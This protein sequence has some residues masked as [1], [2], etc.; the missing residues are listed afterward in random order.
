MREVAE[1]KGKLRV[2]HS[3]KEGPIVTGHVRKN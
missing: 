3:R 2:D 1:T